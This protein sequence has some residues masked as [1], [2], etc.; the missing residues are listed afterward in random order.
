MGSMKKKGKQTQEIRVEKA[1][2]PAAG[3]ERVGVIPKA[4]LSIDR[5]SRESR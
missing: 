5:G 2:L 1:V 4:M 3:K